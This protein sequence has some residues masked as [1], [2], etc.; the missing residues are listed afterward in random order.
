MEDRELDPK[1]LVRINPPFEA[2]LLE[3]IMC[4]MKKNGCRGRRLL[5]EEVQQYHHL[6]EYYAWTGSHR[7]VAASQLNLPTVPFRVI[8]KAE[9]DAAF[10]KAGYIRNG[11][12]CWR[13]AVMG[14][15]GGQDPDRLR[16]L[17]KAGLY[18]AAQMLREELAAEDGH[19]T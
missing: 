8:T 6:I 15:E 13:D 12:S 9:A 14:R 16:G 19:R 7:I 17:E 5:V 11:Y 2:S 10:S 3:R 1:E 4:N 18:E